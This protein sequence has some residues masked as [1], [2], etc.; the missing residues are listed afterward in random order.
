MIYIEIAV[1]VVIPATTYLIQR[2]RHRP[3]A[4]PVTLSFLS[5]LTVLVL[6]YLQF[7]KQFH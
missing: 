1:L 7:A 6:V 5:V 4:L 3:A 2:L